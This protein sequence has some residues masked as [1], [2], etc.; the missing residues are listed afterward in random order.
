[1]FVVAVVYVL[2]VLIVQC[3]CFTVLRA[4]TAMHF[5]KHSTVKVACDEAVN[6]FLSMG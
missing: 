4:V 2:D 3:C 1:M 5:W 6:Y